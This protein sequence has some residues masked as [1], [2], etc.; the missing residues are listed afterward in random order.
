MVDI[1]GQFFPET[2]FSTSD[3]SVLQFGLDKREEVLYILV[4]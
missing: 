3:L 2:D 4:K 1:G